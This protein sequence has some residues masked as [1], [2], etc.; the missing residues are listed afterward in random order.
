MTQSI[1]IG[2]WETAAGFVKINLE[3]VT[4]N[5]STLCFVWASRFSR[6]LRFGYWWPLIVTSGTRTLFVWFC[7]FLPGDWECPFRT[8]GGQEMLNFCVLANQ[9]ASHQWCA[10]WYKSVATF[11]LGAFSNLEKNRL[12]RLWEQREEQHAW[13]IW[14]SHSRI[15]SEA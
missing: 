8:Q 2:A 15:S 14:K 7:R 11:S 6:L 5:K 4:I 10:Q 1:D 12:V 9:S 3:R 13:S